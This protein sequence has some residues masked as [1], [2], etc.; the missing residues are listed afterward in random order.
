MY[1]ISTQILTGFE[2][3]S[4]KLFEIV[5]LLAFVLFNTNVFVSYISIR[6]YRIETK[7]SDDV[8]EIFLPSFQNE[9]ESLQY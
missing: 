8:K 2:F 4:K 6:L 7:Y 3:Q 9:T 1:T 5:H